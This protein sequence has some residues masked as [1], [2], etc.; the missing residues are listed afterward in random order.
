MSCGLIGQVGGGSQGSQVK[1]PD[2]SVKTMTAAHL[3]KPGSTTLRMT[4]GIITATTS[5]SP[6][7]TTSSQQVKNRVM[8]LI[9][10]EEAL[11]CSVTAFLLFIFDTLFL[12]MCILYCFYLLTYCLTLSSVFYPPVSRGS[13]SVP[14]VLRY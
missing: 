5:S 1:L 12:E 2:G 11:D 10:K 9:T 4:G 14:C 8:N 13:R 6:A 3:S 7:A